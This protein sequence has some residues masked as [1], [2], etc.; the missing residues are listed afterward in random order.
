[1]YIKL[2]LFPT[3]IIQF[4]PVSKSSASSH[5][6]SLVSFALVSPSSF[7]SLDPPL[8]SLAAA[9]FGISSKLIT[10]QHQMPDIVAQQAG[11]GGYRMEEHVLAFVVGPIEIRRV[12]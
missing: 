3:K 11:G 2:L 4:L 8:F 1:M 9:A 12:V 10:P 6:S 5:L 7:P